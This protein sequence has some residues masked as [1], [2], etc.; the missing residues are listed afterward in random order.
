MINIY[1]VRNQAEKVNLNKLPD[2]GRFFRYEFKKLRFPGLHF[3]DTY[4]DKKGNLKRDIQRPTNSNG[5]V[6][7]F[8]IPWE[9]CNWNCL[10]CHQG[11]LRRKELIKK[12]KEGKGIL[13]LKEAKNLIQ[14]AV[15]MGVRGIM[16]LGG[17]MLIEGNF[18]NYTKELLEFIARFRKDSNKL[19]PEPIPVIYS[20]GSGITKKMAY[21]LDKLGVSLS[22]KFDSLVPTKFEKISGTTGSFKKT[23]ELLSTLVNREIFRP[24]WENEL[25]VFTPLQFI[26]VGC[27]LSVGEYPRIAYFAS[28]LGVRWM[29]E[30]LNIIGS[31][32][33]NFPKEFTKI[34]QEKFLQKHLKYLRKVYRTNPAQRGFI[35]QKWPCILFESLTVKSNLSGSFE[36]QTCPQDYHHPIIGDINSV[37]QPLHVAWKRYLKTEHDLLCRKYL[38][39]P[40]CPIKNQTVLF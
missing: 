25:A 29:V 38:Q 37:K 18:W 3:P 26:T 6:Y 39:D 16:L 33:L 30:Y 40:I 14:E 1:Q 32:E 19:I 4:F 9:L 11:E 22:L 34:R 12:F 15:S 17:E 5:P 28:Q 31:A 20:N 13:P 10:Y 36:I 21:E 35:T 8:L 27:P 23:L 24:R 2:K 7:L